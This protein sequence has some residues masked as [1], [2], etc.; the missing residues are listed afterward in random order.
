[1]IQG[2]DKDAHCSSAIR[3]ALLALAA[4]LFPVLAGGFVRPA[5][6]GIVPDFDARERKEITAS[7]QTPGAELEAMQKRGY[8]FSINRTTGALR[9]LMALDGNLLDD[10][11]SGGPIETAR[12]AVRIHEALLGLSSEGAENL[13]LESHYRTKHNGIEHVWF[14]QSYRDIEVFNGRIGVHMDR[15]G[16]VFA[17]S[18]DEIATA[19]PETVRADLSAW[20][21]VR[22][23]SESVREPFTDRNL[24]RELSGVASRLRIFEQSHLGAPPEARLMLFNMGRAAKPAWVIRIDPASAFASYLVIV[25]AESG[26]VLFRKNMMLYGSG[27]VYPSDPETD[28]NRIRV[29][30]GVTPE[31]PSSWL[32]AADVTSGNNVHAYHDPGRAFLF[33][34]ADGTPVEIASPSAFQEFHYPIDLTQSPETY[35]DAAISNLFYLNNFIHDYLYRLGF[36]E[37][38]GNYQID[39]FG[40]GGTAGDQVNAEAQDGWRN[41][42]N[43]ILPM[44]VNN[45][46]F[47]PSAD[48][49]PGRMQIY[50]WTIPTPYR[51]G[52]LDRDL[53]VHEYC[54]GLTNRLVGGPASA[55]S[56]DN[57]QGGSMGEGWSDFFA[58]SIAGDDIVG[59]YPTGWEIGIR[60]QPY[61]VSAYTFGDLGQIYDGGCE[62]HYDGEIWAT[63]L[64]RLQN[65]Y[66]MIYGTTGRGMFEQ[67]VV[68]SLKI[69]AARPSFLDARDAMVQAAINNGEDRCLVWQMFA[70]RGMGTDASVAGNGCDQVT[71][72]Y[73]VPAGCACVYPDPPGNLQAL[74]AEPD[75][76]LSWSSQAASGAVAYQVLR[77]AGGCQGDFIQAGFTREPITS[78]TDTVPAPDLYGYKINAVP[79]RGTPCGA[80]SAC[81]EEEVGCVPGGPDVEANS[82]RL[83][84]SGADARLVWVSSGTGSWNVHNTMTASDL[85]LLYQDPASI[86]ETTT[87]T[88]SINTIALGPGEVLYFSVFGADGCTGESIP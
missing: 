46:N 60:S 6:E 82:L 44:A 87:T 47:T 84:K 19:F 61:S 17:L 62:V 63:L 16:R 9:S 15:T 49:Q 68:D 83:E 54:H 78:F 65:D 13:V 43:L 21:A 36:D 76:Q 55:N 85:P 12:Q 4:A 23:A 88:E 71:E 27:L 86:I 53:V 8:L 35:R 48:G 25:D 32:G 5:Q 64:W 22:I 66:E 39:N 50:V 74:L 57:H 67:N 20:E 7:L 40:L 24:P 42:E 3:V 29:D 72:G 2:N 81:I 41:C 51:D 69:M 45:A 33:F 11:R 38:A 30:F 52:D 10:A 70:S 80:A 73:D 28:I 56:L 58:N 37:Q 79:D 75:V 34:C 59:E 1:M 14:V 26:E 31:S 77:A 18:S